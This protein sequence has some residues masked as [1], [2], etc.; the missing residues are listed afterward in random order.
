MQ[1]KHAANAH[2]PMLSVGEAAAKL[3]VSTDTLKRWEKS[4]RIGSLR[5]PTNHRRYRLSEI[6][7]LLAE[8]VAS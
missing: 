5:T 2:D 7:A 3:G 6:D 1:T 4:G 8:V